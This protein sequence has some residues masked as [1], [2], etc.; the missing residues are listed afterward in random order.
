MIF[1]HSLK[2]VMIAHLMAWVI[3][4][5]RQGK[6][7]VIN[8]I[9]ISRF[10]NITKE[11]T[12]EW[13]EE[14]QQIGKSISLLETL[15]REKTPEEGVDIKSMAERELLVLHPKSYIR[16][17][18]ELQFFV[19]FINTLLDSL[20]HS[21]V[22]NDENKS[23]KTPLVTTKTQLTE[24]NAVEILGPRALIPQSLEEFLQNNFAFLALEKQ[25]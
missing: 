22:A 18:L 5:K 14:M 15:C 16:G 19:K 17:K 23:T 7:P 11:L 9:S 13:K 10:F 12:L 21:V 2:G 20:K 3:C 6:S 25:E 4:L 1:M 24:E 8:N